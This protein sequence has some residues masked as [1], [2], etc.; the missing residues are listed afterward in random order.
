MATLLVIGG[1]GFFGKSILDSY[2]RG[3]LNPWDIDTVMVMA[4]NAE[5][6][7]ESNPELLSD[8]V[9][10]LNGDI[11]SCLELPGADYVIH[12]A[13]S[14][15]VRNYLTSPDVE[16]KNIQAGTYNYCELAK[17]FHLNSRILYCSS[18]AIYG[19]QPPSMEY[20][21]EDYVGGSTD[22]MDQ[23]KKDYAAA[24]RDGEKAIIE[25]GKEGLKVSIARC[26]AFVGKYL[27]RDQ[28]FAIG[29][30]IED[31]RKGRSIEVKA[32][33]KVYRSYMHADDLASWLMTIC[34]SSNQNCPIYNVG[35]DCSVDMTELA[36]LV[37]LEFNVC[38]TA[39]EIVSNVVDRYVP[40]I[41]RAQNQLGLGLTIDIKQAIKATIDSID[42][43]NASS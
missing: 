8:S 6:L 21:S 28:H 41:L 32:R 31:G 1:S 4:R 12:A 36:N 7:K 37:G 9:K 17:K 42:I 43:N 23:T 29:N 38:I 22:E 40:S 25:L 30:F 16:K 10:L 19:Q 5:G 18:G 34:H 13:A 27:P 2:K 15:D 11:S 3:L 24:K 39:H 20:L 26:F 14:T 35:S 33:H